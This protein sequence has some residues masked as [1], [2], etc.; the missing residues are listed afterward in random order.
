MIHDLRTQKGRNDYAKG[1]ADKTETFE[2]KITASEFGNLAKFYKRFA[3]GNRLIE[4]ESIEFEGTP[5]QHNTAI[6]TDNIVC[7][8]NE[9]KEKVKQ[10]I[11]KNSLQGESFDV[12]RINK[13]KRVSILDEDDL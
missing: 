8:E 3:K 5:D 1:N 12:Y 4:I 10:Y 9:L 7:T 6:L 2:I 11:S 13:G